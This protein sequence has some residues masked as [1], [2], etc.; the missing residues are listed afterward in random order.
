M[1]GKG[2]MCVKETFRFSRLKVILISALAVFLSCGSTMSAYAMPKDLVVVHTGDSHSQVEGSAADLGF[3]DIAAYV[4]SLKH[5]GKTVI[6][7]DAGDSFFGRP[8]AAMDGGES[9]VKILNEVGYDAMTVGNHE[10]DM[11]QDRFYMLNSELKY[12]DICAN[13]YDSKGNRLLPPYIIK[14]YDGFK[15]GIF[16]LSTPELPSKNSPANVEGLVLTDPV[17]ETEK[18][19]T[20]LDAKTDMIIGITHLGVEAESGHTSV[21]LATKVKG[22][23][24]I[25]DGHSHIVLPEGQV[26][27]DTLIGSVGSYNKYLGVAEFSIDSQ[28]NITSAKDRLIT[29]AGINLEPDPAIKAIVDDFENKV[30]K[31]LDVKIATL[32]VDMNGESQ[33]VR[34][35]EAQVGCMLADALRSASG[36]DLAIVNSGSIRKSL[37]A[38]DLTKRDILEMLP[39]NNVLVT[40]NVS[41][42]A[43]REALENGVKSY[44]TAAGCF[45]QVSG[46]TFT[47]DPVKPAGSRVS[48]IM[49]AGK[50]LVE[51]QLY[52]VAT[53][54]FMAGGGDGYTSLKVYGVEG[55]NLSMAE[56]M[57]D[58]MSKTKASAVTMGRIVILPVTN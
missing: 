3:A 33:V 58:Y 8:I 13:L 31:L 20:D 39:F 45:P 16:G 27:G 41:G 21:E 23:D 57:M 30:G 48:K 15:V 9:V 46:V 6:V 38:G 10:F 32:D 12:P 26:A 4:D 34:T 19:I 18:F 29:K 2:L 56:V 42:A 53:N 50:P 55:G 24:F 44:P 54:D 37:V 1:I 47:I 17:Q 52:N 5:A 43:I 14:D 22:I 49:V 51:A 25:V 7:L 28:G 35:G 40:G 36:A 11:G